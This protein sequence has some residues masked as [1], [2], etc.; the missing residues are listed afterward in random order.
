MDSNQ[1]P[2]KGPKERSTRYSAPLN[3][4]L[5]ES[6]SDLLIPSYDLS[7]LVIV[8][9]IPAKVD[10][11]EIEDLIREQIGI[12]MLDNPTNLAHEQLKIMYFMAEDNKAAT[13]VSQIPEIQMFMKITGVRIYSGENPKLDLCQ[14]KGWNI[15]QNQASAVKPIE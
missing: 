11:S 2:F 12:I 13:R 1:N 7:R 6:V 4:H 9:K 10:L 8:D 14:Y 5:L 15:F 3:C